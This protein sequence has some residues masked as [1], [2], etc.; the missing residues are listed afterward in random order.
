[1]MW[2]DPSLAPMVAPSDRADL[3]IARSRA[4]AMIEALASPSSLARWASPE[5]AP[6]DVHV[7]TVRLDPAQWDEDLFHAGL[8]EDERARARRS[9]LAEVRRRFAVCRASLRAILAGYLDIDPA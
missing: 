8:S 1:M 6:D 4:P 3:D 2:Q 5:L 7:W 9:P